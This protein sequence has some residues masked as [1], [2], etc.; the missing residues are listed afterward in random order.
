[1]AE[2]IK[3]KYKGRVEFELKDNLVVSARLEEPVINPIYIEQAYILYVNPHASYIQGLADE[4]WKLMIFD[5]IET[6]SKMQKFYAEIENRTL[7]LDLRVT[8]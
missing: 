3:T 1:M 7:N 8:G 5:I 4:S 6:T 2:H